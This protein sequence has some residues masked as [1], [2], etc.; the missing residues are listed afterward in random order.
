[1]KRTNFYLCHN[2]TIGEMQICFSHYYPTLEINFFCN[3]KN[4]HP[5]GARVMLS[6]EVK[7]G[8]ISPDC[9]NGCVVLNNEMTITE[10]E[11]AIND[12]FKVHSEI[13][14]VNNGKHV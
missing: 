9:R 3:S 11:D 1:M 6:P 4:P 5:D 12:H 7:I 8:T 13:C 14:P 10:L 2:E